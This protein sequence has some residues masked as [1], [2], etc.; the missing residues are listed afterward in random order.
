MSAVPVRPDGS[1]AF[2]PVRPGEYLACHLP[3]DYRTLAEEGEPPKESMESAVRLKVA[4]NG[5]H[6]VQLKAVRAAQ[7]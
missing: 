1:F 7:D 4:P 6:T 3:G 2:A 5:T